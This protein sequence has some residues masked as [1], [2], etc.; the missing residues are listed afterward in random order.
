[1]WVH[2]V[3]A[4][5]AALRYSA[6]D[7][8]GSSVVLLAGMGLA[9][10]ETYMPALGAASLRGRRLVFVDPFGCGYS[11][12]PVAFSYSLGD[13]ADAI[14]GLLRERLDPPCVLVGYSAGGAIAAVLAD[15]YPELVERLVLVEAALAQGGG[16][17]SPWIADHTER[18]FLDHGHA[19]LLERF[20]ATGV[21]GAGP[22]ALHTFFARTPAF[23]L[24]R[25]ASALVEPLTRDVGS[26][27]VALDLPRAY[28]AGASPGSEL[29]EED[30]A[31]LE[32]ASID[33]IRIP[34][35]G[36]LLPWE[37]PRHLSGALADTVTTGPGP[38]R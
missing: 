32:Q 13:Q 4:V 37:N 9:A 24:Y 20:D 7:G 35:A 2:R 10:A 3:D 6:L 36:H 8:P 1:V 5:G 11:D 31:T 27:F 12:A 26:R 33:V 29:G 16:S 22:A 21:A 15:E 23:A 17:I 25:M 18:R 19:A 14:A 28:I 34:E 30:H 38:R